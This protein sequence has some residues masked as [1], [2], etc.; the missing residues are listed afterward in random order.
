MGRGA[1]NRQPCHGDQRTGKPYSTDEP[2]H[3]LGGAAQPEG[4]S[5]QVGRGASG[6]G[7]ALTQRRKDT[8]IR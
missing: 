3:P 5:A 6:F 7:K 4:K 1:R 2:T 8:K